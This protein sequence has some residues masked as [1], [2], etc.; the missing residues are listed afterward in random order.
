MLVK[1]LLGLAALLAVFLVV[2]AL[3][4]S[5]YRVARSVTIA[6]PAA[7]VFAQ[8]NDLHRWAAWSPWEK[9]DPAM[10]RTLEG[11]PDGVGASYA[12][13]GNKEVGAGRMTIVESRPA[14][15]IR[16]KLE[17]FE[18]MASICTT[19]FVFAPT[20]GQTAVTWTMTGTNN[21]LGK[22]FCLF[23]D[24]DKMVGSDFARGLAELKSVS[25]A[26]A[27]K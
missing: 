24:M 3:Q 17:F 14:E 22:A 19:E 8:V 5:A 12:W 15:L 20:G 9:L 13:R 10:H 7:T 11:A 21:F 16:I 18:P 23:M 6:A 26:A 25:E 1:I 27:P 4:P 2:V